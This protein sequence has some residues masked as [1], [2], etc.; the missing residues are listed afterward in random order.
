V[1]D[2]VRDTLAGLITD[3]GRVLAGDPRRLEALLRDLCGAQ[4]R[5]INILTAA[6]REGIPA[7]LIAPPPGVPPYLLGTRLVQRLKDNLGLADDA[8]RW[9]VESWAL[10]LRVSLPPG[11]APTTSG[12]TALAVDGAVDARPPVSPTYQE[13]Q[14]RPA[15]DPPSNEQAPLPAGPAG[16]GTAGG[17]PWCGSQQVTTVT[18]TS[19]HRERGLPGW[20]LGLSVLV[21]LFIIGLGLASPDEPITAVFLI[22]GGGIGFILAPTVKYLR[23][24]T[25]VEPKRFACSS[26]GHVWQ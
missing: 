2:Q 4:E 23:G 14:P 15:P 17:C 3:Y 10:A 26:C 25:T 24:K 1:Q 7:D 12:G 8:A 20:G 19:P 18:G 21:G 11:A 9:A 16:P 13:Q 22:A 5:E 6:Q